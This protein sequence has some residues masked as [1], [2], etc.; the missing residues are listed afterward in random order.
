MKKDSRKVGIFSFRVASSFP[1]I[2]L[3]LVLTS[4]A[5]ADLTIGSAI[6]LSD[7]VTEITAAYEKR[8]GSKVRTTFSGTNVIAR[9]IE[10]GAP[11]DVFISADTATLEALVKRKL[12]SESTIRT[13][14]TNQLVVVVPVGSET[15]LKSPCDLLSLKRIA[16]A[17]PAS[18][19]A[20]IYAKNWLTAEN[21]W[22]Q[23]QPKTIALQNV[24]AALIAAETWNAD[25]AIVYRSDAASSDR[26]KS[27]FTAPMDK[28]GSIEYPA[29]IV[30]ASTR[31]DE[32]L[33]F[34][35]FIVS[36]EA[37]RMLTRHG[38]TVLQVAP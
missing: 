13:I 6:S 26:V 18:V 36:E 32:A 38:F 16:I 9:Q 17:D 1:A 23:L 7:A 12:I 20:G 31:K 10:A 27:I 34:L 15:T 24:R 5:K 25:A 37:G 29:A 33:A 11:I 22:P 28:T 35:D 8:S 3:T 14:A 30:S 2:L 21:L 4:Q 19:P